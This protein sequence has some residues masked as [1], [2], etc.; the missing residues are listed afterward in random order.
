MSAILNIG[1]S[2]ICYGDASISS[3]PKRRFVD[4]TRNTQG[5]VVGNPKSEQFVVDPGATFTV[6]DG[7]RTT[8]IDATTAFTVTSNL[9]DP[10]RFRFTN[11]AGTA[12]VFRTDRGLALNGITVTVAVNT[13]GSASFS[14]SGGSWG[15][16]VAGDVLFIP[17][18]VSGDPVGPF[19]ALN[20]GY[21]LVLSVSG[22]TLTAARPLGVTFQGAGQVVPVTSNA[23]IMAFSA[24]GVQPSDKVDIA[25]GFSSGTLR[26]FTVVAVTPKWFEVSSSVPLALDVGILPGVTGMAFYKFSKSYVRIECDQES[27]I[28]LNFDSG[29]TQ[30]VSPIIPGDADNMGWFEKFGPAWNCSVVNRTSVPLNINV[31]TTE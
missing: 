27:V 31:I 21:W 28:R 5:L 20:E 3:N 15:T 12:P 23:Q 6:F 29:N 18:A 8:S 26:T 13:N 7:T 30:R 24:A 22:S 25:A 10:S 14:L 19:S 11:T 2:I 4:W 1:V 9:L 16:A 17:G